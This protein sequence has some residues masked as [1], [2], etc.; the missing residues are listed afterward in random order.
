MAASRR[1]ARRAAALL[2]QVLLGAL[3]LAGCASSGAHWHDDLPSALVTARRDGSDV[4]ACFVRP[5]TALSD[6]LQAGLDDA[7]VLT[8]LGKGGFVAVRVDAGQ[9]ERLFEQWLGGR[10]GFGVAVIDPQGRVYSA[11]PG[12]LD[13]DELAAFLNR[14]ASSRERLA[15]ARAEVLRPESGLSEQHALGCLL[16]ELGARRDCEPL[17]IE[18]AMGGVTDARHRLARLYALDGNLTK[19]RNW[20]KSAPGTTAAKVTEGYVLYKERQFDRAAE[21]FEA[22][23]QAGRVGDERQ[24]AMLYL[25]KSWHEG[26]RDDRAV[27]LLESLAREG[28]G[29]VFEA[30]AAHVLRHVRD[31]TGH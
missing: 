29:S 15:A 16:L 13:P 12:P 14:A 27:P 9:Q 2:P 23:L 4:V 24:F 31:G 7:L 20:L 26:R 8:A 5:G 21:V 6:H 17:L 10:D 19:A 1:G 30:G 22:A 28:T 25:G 18:A 11:R 3:S